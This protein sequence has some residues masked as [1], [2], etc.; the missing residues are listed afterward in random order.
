MT[1]N[2]DININISS[3]N[4]ELER[5]K[6]AQMRKRKRKKEVQVIITVI[7]L[8]VM[9][10]VLTLVFIFSGPK[11]ANRGA[12]KVEENGC[13]AFYPKKSEVHGENFAKELCNSGN[14]D[15]I[16]DYTETEFGDFTIYDYGNSKSFMT[17][18][19]GTAVVIEKLPDG[20]KIVLSDY[21]RYTMKQKGYDEAYTSAFL[22]ETY[23]KNL[24]V[25]S[26]KYSFDAENLICRFPE[27]DVNVS[28]PLKYVP[29]VF[30]F[31]LGVEKEQ[32]IKPV[33]VDPNR[34]MV[35]LTFDDGPDINYGNTDKILEELTKYDGVG[36]FFTVGRSLSEDAVPILKKGIER[37]C[38]YGSHS[39]NHPDLSSLESSEITTEVMYVADF[40]SENLGYTVNIYRPPYGIYDGNVDAA[41]PLAAILWDVDSQDWRYQNGPEIV[42]SVQGDVFD[43]AVILL[44]DIHDFSAAAVCEDG[45]TKWL[46][47]EGYQLVDVNTIA[48]QRG[49]ELTQGVHLCWD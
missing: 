4:R 34:P 15:V 24:N 47:D 3:D 29:D 14:R 12:E 17:D 13:I 27:Y 22:E 20:F 46:V 19:K 45:L 6:A 40:F 21:L 25:S 26:F 37:G 10:L 11:S 44:H 16:Y 28:I 7:I 8:L 2:N 41:V 36:T 23:Y 38:Q 1:E 33:Y 48:E 30:N 5:R 18:K 39:T 9:V 49:V 32:Y 35:A 42:S 31:D 43:K